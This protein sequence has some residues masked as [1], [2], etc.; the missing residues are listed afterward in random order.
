MR[1]DSSGWSGKP[2]F[3][4]LQT[5][6]TNSA[7]TVWISQTHILFG[8]RELVCDRESATLEKQRENLRRTVR[9]R[10]AIEEDRPQ[11]TVPRLPGLRA[12]IGLVT[13]LLS[14]SERQERLSIQYE[15]TLALVGRYSCCQ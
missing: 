3:L 8:S 5:P 9:P 2:S 14:T 6:C 12:A 1:P 13:A 7:K 4:T 15:L 10:R 11:K